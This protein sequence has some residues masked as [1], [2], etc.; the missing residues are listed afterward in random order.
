MKFKATILLTV[1]TLVLI[2]LT[3]SGRAQA[4]PGIPA[5]IQPTIPALKPITAASLAPADATGTN[6]GPTTIQTVQGMGSTVAGWFSSENPANRYQDLLF[7]TGAVNQNN[8]TVANETGLS[9]DIWRQNKDYYPFTSTNTVN[10]TLFAAVESRTRMAG[11]GGAFQS[12]GVGPEFGWMQNDVRVGVFASAVYRFSTV[13]SPSN[14]KMRGEF[15]VFADKMLTA[16]SAI[17]LM[18][19]FQTG[20]KYPFVGGQFN[21]SFGNG[22]GFLGL[23]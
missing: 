10:S 21:V 19:S 14:A 18:L 2:S 5:D 20:E 12:E 3:L 11:I 23:F 6:N 16:N 7:W 1:L 15:G 13:G 22:K 17:G 4:Q 8:A 9:Y